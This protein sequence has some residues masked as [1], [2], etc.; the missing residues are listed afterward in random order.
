MNWRPWKISLSPGLSSQPASMEPIMTTLPPAAM[1]LTMSPEY[2]MPPSAMMGTPYLSAI[3]ALCSMAVICGT[4]MPLTTRVVHMEPGPMPT[5]TQSA[6]AFIRASVPSAVATLPAMRP[7]SGKCSLT[8]PTQR[9]ML[10]LCPC[11]ES[12]TRA[13]APAATS[14]PARSR[15]SFV[16]PIAAAQSRRPWLSLAELGYLTTFSM[17]FIVM[18]PLRWNFASTMGSF[19]ILCLRRISLASS[20]VVPSR[21]VTRP[22]LVMTSRIGLVMSSSNFMSRF[23]MMPMSL[24]ALSTMGTPEM[25]NLPMRASASPRVLSGPR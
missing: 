4:P 22:S 12:S 16:T 23:V 19:S 5:F 10:A 14:A 1:A 25:R 17:S 6:P 20:S 9:M 3:S 21:P 13:S 8:R 2:L 11:A 24:P 18:R 15:M 7:T